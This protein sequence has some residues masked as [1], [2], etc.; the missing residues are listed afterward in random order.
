M[1]D[2]T[3]DEGECILRAKIDMNNA[4]LNL[5][6]PPLYRIKHHNHPKTGSLW[7]I[8]PMYDFAHV[9]S[10]AIENITHSLCS[11]E[12]ENHRPLYDWIVEKLRPSGLLPNSDKGWRPY[13]YEFSRLNLQYSVLSKR[14]LIQLVNGKYVD[15]WDDPRLPTIC[16]LRNR[17]FPYEAIRL[18]CD[19]VGVSKVDSNIDYSILEDSVREI[20]DPRTL[21]AFAI[22]EPLK[23]TISNWNQSEQAV[24][25]IHAENHP[26]KPELGVRPLP[27]TS[28]ILIDRNDFFDC[29]INNEFNAPKGFKRLKLG[30]QVRLKYAY[31]ITCN[32][33]VRGSSGEVVELK[34]SF[35]SETGGGKKTINSSKAKGIIQWI[36]ANHAVPAEFYLY[37]RLFTHPHPANEENFLAHLNP[38][39][40]KIVKN[41]VVESNLGGTK[42][43]SI[44]QFE[45]MGYFVVRN[46]IDRKIHFNRV[47]TL[48]DTWKE[49]SIDKT[50]NQ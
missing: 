48:K 8:Y 13:Q 37:D 32:E 41:A 34:C 19:R 15:G 20:L 24:E 38:D 29:G 31:V 18:F 25:W 23:V 45:R 7:N 9:I 50:N 26:K 44:Y 43:G 12:F 47:V 4:N 11:L 42:L 5:R 49:R 21:R 39:S 40:L 22:E 27:F 33:V 17:G 35:D 28:S 46:L 3:F 10:D 1:R 16:G 6:D 36:S 30:G 2:G 14:K